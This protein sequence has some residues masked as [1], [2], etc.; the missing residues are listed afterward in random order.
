[1]VLNNKIRNWIDN[2]LTFKTH[3]LRDETSLNFVRIQKGNY[4][5]M[6]KGFYHIL[7]LRVEAMVGQSRYVKLA[8]W[9]SNL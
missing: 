4:A 6:F 7:T 5:F 2:L 8:L 3:I 1:M 9:G